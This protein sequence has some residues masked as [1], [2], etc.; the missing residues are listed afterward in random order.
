MR[1][2]VILLNRVGYY[3]SRSSEKDV[4]E[5]EPVI[6]DVTPTEVIQDQQSSEKESAEVSTAGA[7]QGTASE[8]VPIVSTTEESE[9]KKKS[10]KELEQERL[11]LAEAIRL[12][13]QINEEQRV[14]IARDEE[15]AR[16]W[17]EE[18]RQRAMAEAKGGGNHHNLRR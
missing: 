16:Q 15:I 18:E 8:E 9:P 1:M 3:L 12:E 10:K 7:K 11:S 2:G 13:E 17:D 5:T 4:N 6:Q 14:Q